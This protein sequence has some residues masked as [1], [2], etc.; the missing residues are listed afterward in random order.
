MGN[1]HVEEN[2]SR[3]MNCYLCGKKFTVHVKIAHYEIDGK[4]RDLHQRCKKNLI[5]IKENR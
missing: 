1:C 4:E 3:G 2:R 5:K